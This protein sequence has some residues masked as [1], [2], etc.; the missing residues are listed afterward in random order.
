MTPC[1]F[2]WEAG[3]VTEAMWQCGKACALRGEVTLRL[4]MEC[5]K[6]KDKVLHVAMCTG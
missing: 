2:F 6:E 1:M 3:I 4:S 5:R